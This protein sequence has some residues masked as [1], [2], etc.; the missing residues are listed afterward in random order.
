MSSTLFAWCDAPAEFVAASALKPLEVWPA[1]PPVGES[2]GSAA[3]FRVS[4]SA[5]G[6]DFDRQVADA[7]QFLHDHRQE[8]IRLAALPGAKM[9]LFFVAGQPDRG[10]APGGGVVAWHCNYPAELVRLAAEL[11]MSLGVK[12]DPMK[13]HMNPHAE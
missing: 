3:G 4:V 7:L 5:D 12:C 9:H 2:A 6:S 8:L 11:G 1:R 13:L 10:R